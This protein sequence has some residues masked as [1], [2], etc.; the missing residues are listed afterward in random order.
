MSLGKTRCMEKNR[1]VLQDTDAEAIALA[2]QLIAA[3][4]FATLAVIDPETGFPSASRIL[5]VADEDGTPVILVSGLS[6]H[7]RALMADPRCGL[8]FGEPGKGDPMAHARL[9]V[10]CL[11]ETTTERD[12]AFRDRLRS[13][14]LA[15]HPKAKL[16]IDLPDFRFLRLLPRSA[17]LNGGFGR[18]YVLSGEQLVELPVRNGE[19]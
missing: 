1:S 7:T 16:Y 17:S 13:L 4:P 6:A 3:A 14:F 15:R 9:S 8:L 10:Q 2:R 19:S 18:A 5:T 12:Q 11:C